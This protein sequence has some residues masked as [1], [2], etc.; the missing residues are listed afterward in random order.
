MNQSSQYTSQVPG[1]SR[2]LQEIEKNAV[3][4]KDN[5]D[6]EKLIKN[7]ADKKIVM[8]GE[9][10]HGTEEFYK[11]RR[12]L[13]QELIQH[14]GF[15]FIAVEGDWPPSAELNRFVHGGTR[16]KAP[17]DALKSF[18]RWPTW[19]WANTEIV[20]LA[21]WLKDY[22]KKEKQK[23]GFFGLDVY[24]L[25]ESIDEIIKQLNSIDPDLAHHIQSQY[26]CFDPY[27]RDERTYA[28]S[29]IQ[30]PEGC[31]KQVLKA[32]TDLLNVRLDK[33]TRHSEKYFDARQNARIVKNAERYYRAMIQGEEDSWNVR[34]RHMIE[35]LDI[36]LNRHGENSKAIVWA[37][38]THIGDY[39][40]TPMLQEGQV[41]IGGLAREHWG[42]DEVALVGFGT[43]QGEVIA[44]HAWD[45]PI[46][47]MKVP[48]GREQSYEAYFHEASKHLREDSFYIWLN[49][50]EILSETYGHRAIGVVY[51]P[52]HERFGNYVPSSLSKRYDAFV[53][54]DKTTALT[55]LKQDFKR[56]EIPETWPRGT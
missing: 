15:S 53:F 24:S 46:E 8:L 41:N 6:L 28:R 48:P 36:L 21:H 38:N 25:F 4:L 2:I 32:L 14:H 39:R 42:A 33:M 43:Y 30:F 34:D 23:V 51:D 11:W 26:A 52:E 18:Q 27:K 16:T 9:S 37:H 12:L 3:P 20:R 47:V 45:G 10:S 13:S 44:S 7:I 22:N 5:R 1:S 50:S 54:I 40:A 17:E 31:E 49:N 56:D 29:L 55:P 35:T 19:M